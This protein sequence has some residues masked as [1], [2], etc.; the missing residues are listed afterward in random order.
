MSYYTGKALERRIHQ[1]GLT[2]VYVALQT[3]AKGKMVWPT[4]RINLD[5]AV[6]AEQVRNTLYSMMYELGLKPQFTVQLKPGQ[7]VVTEKK[8]RT[9]VTFDDRLDKLP[10]TLSTSEAGEAG[11]GEA[12]GDPDEGIHNIFD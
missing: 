6:I 2:D 8:K 12:D 4:C 7:L 5:D 1:Y 9:S 10:K 3:Y 11:E